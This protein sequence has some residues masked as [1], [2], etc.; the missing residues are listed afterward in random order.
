MEMNTDIKYLKGVGESRAASLKKLGIGTLGALLRFYPRAYEDWN[1]IVSISDVPLNE[2]LC[3]KG[4]VLHKPSAFKTRNGAMLYKTTVSDGTGLMN[5]TFF[6][7]KYVVNQLS[8]NEDYLFFGKVALN[9]YGAKEMASPRFEKAQGKER[10]RPVYRCTQSLNS[11]AIEK[12]VSTALDAFAGDIPDPI[13]GALIK[14][15]RLPVLAEALRMI[16]FPADESEIAAA[17]RRLVFEELLVLETGLLRLR[18]GAGIQRGRKFKADY[19]G[20]FWALLPFEP[21][22]AQ[23]RAVEQAVADMSS[24]KRMSRLLQGDVGSGKTAVA[25]ALI[26]NAAKNSVQSAL[27]APTEVLAEQHYRTLTKM[28]GGTGL[29]ISLLTGSV[30]ASAKRDIKQ[31]LAD[32]ETDLVI[33]THALIQKDVEFSRLGL[34]ITDE[35]HRFGVAQRNAL[36]DKGEEPH[37]F[38]MSAT[39]IPRTL[40]MIIYGDLDISVLD[41]LPPGRQPIETYKVD[42]AYRDRILKFTQKA[43]DEGRQAYI[44]CPLVEEGESDLIPAT[45]YE[46][47]L[48]STYFK[49]YR[50]GLLHGQM[51]PA[52]KDAVMR[53]FSSG[54][55]QLLVSTVVVEVGVDVP[56][57][58]VMIIENAERFGLSQL[59]QLRGRIGRGE[60]KSTCILVSDAQ[61]AEAVERFKV[62]CE[63]SDGFKI[64][65]KDLELRGPG[66]FF[67]SRQH[68]LPDLKIADVV[69]DTRVLYEAQRVASEILAVDPE[70]SLPE[71]AGL[72]GEISSLFSRA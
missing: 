64:A 38:V 9:M 61:N 51:K 10:I 39:P 55:T 56:N 18:G 67:G 60:H 12:F 31:R 53:S 34:V 41:E 28:L 72:A 57:A 3:I 7:N 23:R 13:P 70:L 43:L 52:E 49:N 69:T 65:D 11:K 40:A 4:T 35:Q 8:E 71:N 62:L 17:R 16:H 15:Y 48:A 1:S 45:E 14:K 47:H 20:E 32:G 50:V 2:T 5:L 58:T 22:P 54:E 6:N 63:T 68:G 37:V 25:A 19:S 30:S 44:I 26:Y 33:G 27:M 59:H 66:D 42:S 46:R 29:S 24:G 36:R 21:T